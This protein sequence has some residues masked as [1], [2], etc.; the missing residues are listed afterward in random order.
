MP[1]RGVGLEIDEDTDPHRRSELRGLAYHRALAPRLR[2]PMVDE[3]TRKISRWQ[4]TGRIDPRYARELPAASA[5]PVPELR[6]L[7]SADDARGRDLRQNSP[8]AGLLSE[9][10]GAG[11]SKR[12][13]SA[14]AQRELRPRDCCRGRVSGEREIVVI[15]SQAILGSVEE[16]PETLAESMEADVFP[17]GD[18]EKAIEIEAVLGEGSSF[19]GLYGYYAHG[20]GPETMKGPEGWRD[21]LIRVKVPPRPGQKAEP[22]ALCLELHDLVLA[23]CAA[24]RAARLGL[25]T[26]D[27]SP[28]GWSTTRCWPSGSPKCPA[29]SITKMGFARCWRG[30]PRRSL[31][32][33]SRS[34]AFTDRRRYP[35]GYQSGYRTLTKRDKSHGPKRLRF[36]LRS[37][38]HGDTSAVT[39]EVAGSSPVAP[40]RSAC[41]RT[42]LSASPG[43][44]PIRLGL[45]PIAAP[46]LNSVAELC[47]S[48][49]ESWR[50]PGR[51]S[52]PGR[53]PGGSRPLR[54]S[55]R[56]AFANDLRRER[57]SAAVSA[58]VMS[59]GS[60]P[61]IRPGK[62]PPDLVLVVVAAAARRSE[63]RRRSPPKPAVAV[64]D[65]VADRRIRGIVERVVSIEKAD[66][67]VGVEDYRHS[68]RSPST[69]LPQI[70]AGIQA[71][72]VAI[73]QL[74]DSGQDHATSSLGLDL[75][76]VTGLEAALRKAAAGIV[77]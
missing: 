15:G 61:E 26:R 43:A 60:T 52:Q 5:K 21:R 32:I 68:S 54:G 67:R 34:P 59:T 8:F 69:C 29:G 28:W 19:Q 44:S 39:P 23:K 25:C 75:Q 40:A 24:G 55:G 18:P 20:V 37:L 77:T 16:P 56:P 48:G 74:I 7:I 51:R 35:R 9:P 33:P 27:A 64:A 13:A 62:E 12:F 3:A 50:L 47:T 17:L 45:L 38:I 11:S 66:D 65:K 1:D 70:A 71:P 22:I 30:S 46:Q 4:Q 63:P 72:G 42:S 76:G 36:S 73:D 58:T 41:K 2:R 57:S 6:R 49:R 31:S 14:G 53:P 10:E